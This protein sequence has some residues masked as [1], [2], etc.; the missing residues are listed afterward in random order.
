MRLN[1]G[2][3]SGR[4]AL[5]LAAAILLTGCG[6]HSSGAGSVAPSSSKTVT[7]KAEPGDELSPYMVSAVASNKPSTV[8]VQV[9]FE[10][11]ERPDVGQPLDVELAIVPLSASVDQVSGKVEADDGLELIEGGDIAATA[12]PVEGVPIRHALKVVPR[13]EGIFTVRASVTV[14]AAGNSSTETYSIPVIAAAA[15]AENPAGSA[16][17][18]AVAVASRP[19]K[20]P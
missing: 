15:T 13:R 8:P 17:P 20:A 9:K 14:E 7:R 16:A 10:L 11:H 1:A 18:P 5:P 19:G 4:L 6:S 2:L 3:R 12:R